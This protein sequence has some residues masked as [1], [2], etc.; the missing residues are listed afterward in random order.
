M[1]EYDESIA[2]AIKTGLESIANAIRPIGALPGKD[3]TGGYVSSLTE[4]IMGITA[5]L[6]R[7]ANNIELL[8]DMVDALRCNMEDK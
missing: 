3:A 1:D 4:A 7:V 2:I 6:D 8:A 5:G